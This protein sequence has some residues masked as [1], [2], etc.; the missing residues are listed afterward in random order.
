MSVILEKHTICNVGVTFVKFSINNRIVTSINKFE[1]HNFV[2]TVLNSTF[3]R[4]IN[5]IAKCVERVRI[6]LVDSLRRMSCDIGVPK[7]GAP[8]ESTIEVAALAA[9]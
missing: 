5:T 7:I 1:Q 6:T 9:S 3:I 2:D 4:E 8:L